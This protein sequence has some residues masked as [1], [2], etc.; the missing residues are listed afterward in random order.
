MHLKYSNGSRQLVHRY[1]AL[2]GVDPNSLTRCVCCAEQ[3]GQCTVGALHKLRGL[4]TDSAGGAMPYSRSFSRALSVS[5]ALVQ[6]GASTEST[7]TVAKP[8]CCRRSL[9]DA[10]I[11]SVAGQPV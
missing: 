5:Q 4:S 10:W 7:R 6:G 8:A 9:I 3:R 11:T 1:D 2:H